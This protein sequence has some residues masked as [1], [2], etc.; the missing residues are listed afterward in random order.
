MDN[1]IYFNMF[2]ENWTRKSEMLYK[3]WEDFI[4]DTYFIE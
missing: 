3:L 1:V 4:W 2:L